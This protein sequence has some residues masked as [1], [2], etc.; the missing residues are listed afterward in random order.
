AAQLL[1]HRLHAVADAQDRHPQLEDDGCRMD[2]VRFVGR[3]MAAGE[4]DAAG[5]EI[6]NETGAYVAGVDFAIDAGFAHP[7][8]DQLGDLRTEIET[9]DRLVLHRWSPWHGWT[10]WSGR[11]RTAARSNDRW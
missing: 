4:D 10:R 11:R 5:V 9:A 6:A 3:R 8:C 1:G 2:G 7:P